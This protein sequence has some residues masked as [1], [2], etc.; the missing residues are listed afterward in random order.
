MP[1][2]SAALLITSNEVGA[3]MMVLPELAQSPGMI[4]S[5]GLIL[6]TFYKYA[7]HKYTHNCTGT[8]TYD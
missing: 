2:L 5:S 6:G 7:F 4:V 3:S 1:V 8:G